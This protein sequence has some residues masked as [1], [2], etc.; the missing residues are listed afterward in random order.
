MHNNIYFLGMRIGLL[1][2]KLGLLKLLPKYE[3]TPC[4]ETLIPMR[5]STK[6]LVVAPDG[7]IFLNVRE[8]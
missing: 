1:Q 8:I 2:T 5:F 6:S 3:F 7:G 4:K